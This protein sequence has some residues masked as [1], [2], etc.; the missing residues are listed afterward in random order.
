MDNA[1]KRARV[2]ASVGLSTSFNAM[3]RMFDALQEEDLDS[4]LGYNSI[5]ASVLK[6][7][8]SIR[9]GYGKIMQSVSLDTPRRR[10]TFRRPYIFYKGK[11]QRGK[12]EGEGSCG[13]GEWTSTE[14]DGDLKHMSYRIATYISRCL[15]TSP[16]GVTRNKM[17]GPRS[18]G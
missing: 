10:A 16:R 15:C 1:V 6:Y 9:T 7:V 13:V 18:H 4:K 17:M 11:G 3:K 5:S 8:E 12:G 14:E 2:A